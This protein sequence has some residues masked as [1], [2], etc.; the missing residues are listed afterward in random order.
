M[1]SEGEGGGLNGKSVP[2]TVSTFSVVPF[3]L[4]RMTRFPTQKKT[5]IIM[6]KS[7]ASSVSSPVSPFLPPTL[8]YRSMEWGLK[9]SDH[10]SFDWSSVFLPFI[11][12][13]HF[14]FA[15]SCSLLP[16]QRWLIGGWTRLDVTELVALGI[17]IAQ[18]WEA[19][20]VLCHSFIKNPAVTWFVF[21]RI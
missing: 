16:K 3:F 15:S 13:N 5:I 6:I 20:C 8:S 17:W 2:P 4:Q 1:T 9:Q 7:G 11:F 12:L 18:G 19:V 10:Q 21:G 14:F